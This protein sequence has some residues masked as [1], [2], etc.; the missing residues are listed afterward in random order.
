MRTREWILMFGLAFGLLGCGPKMIPGMDIDIPDTADSRAV[1]KLFEAYQQAMEL[2]KIDALVGMASKRLY[3]TCG[4][5]DT[6]DDYNLDGL[7]Q[8]F[9]DHFKRIEKVLF[10][11][12]LKEVK[13]E[14]D[15]GHLDYQYVARYLMKLPS[16]DK[17]EIADNITRMEV[18]K[19]DGQWKIL[20]GM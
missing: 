7:R 16:G 15:T 10:N 4:T 9:V 14:K 20:N 6:A 12:K 2:K 1:V 8:H 5:N 13:V 3:E 19:E 11:Y 18:V 17:W